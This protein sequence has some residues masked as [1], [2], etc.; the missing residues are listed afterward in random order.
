[1]LMPDW[2]GRLGAVGSG[3]WP[4]VGAQCCTRAI[5][6]NQTKSNL[7][8]FSLAFLAGVARIYPFLWMLK[9]NRQIR[10]S[11]S[12][13]GCTTETQAAPDR[14]H[15]G[16]G[17]RI[18]LGV[19]AWK[20]ARMKPTPM[21]NSSPS[22][23]LESGALDGRCRP[24]RCWRW[25]GV[26]RHGG[27]RTRPGVGGGGAVHPG[28]ISRGLPA[29]LRIHLTLTPIPRWSPKPKS[30]S[31]PAWKRR[32]KRPRPSRNTTKSS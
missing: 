10:I 4:V 1:M 7:L 5:Q 17:A 12:W 21:R 15:R 26:S 14:R 23:N 8:P 25:P 27:R 29:V 11:R 13:N 20:K 28:Q 32:E 6:P 16:G 3:Q 24:P 18:G 22:P 31:P 9:R 2:L 30:E 19:L